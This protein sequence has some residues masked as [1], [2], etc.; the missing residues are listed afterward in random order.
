VGGYL[1]TGSR[2]PHQLHGAPETGCSILLIAAARNGVATVAGARAP[3]LPSLR[4]LCSGEAAAIPLRQHGRRTAQV[5][6]GSPRPPSL[7]E[8]RYGPRSNHHSPE[9]APPQRKN[10]KRLT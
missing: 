9:T 5:Q 1:V 8:V 3:A 2:V 10:H 7:E 6:A 4:R